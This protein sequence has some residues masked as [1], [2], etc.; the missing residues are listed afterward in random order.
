MAAGVPR[1]TV[2][3]R[4]AAVALP[5]PVGMPG[6]PFSEV[7]K[8]PIF[9]PIFGPRTPRS[10]WDTSVENGFGRSGRTTPDLR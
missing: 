1:S 5:R 6:G 9:C 7:R 4:T 8:C 10:G 2:R 3:R